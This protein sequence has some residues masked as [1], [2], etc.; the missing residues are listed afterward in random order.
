MRFVSYKASDLYSSARTYQGREQSPL[1]RKGNGRKAILRSDRAEWARK[2]L[3][4]G[5][6][7][8]LSG[9]WVSGSR[10]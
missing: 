9:L 1:A 10:R 6:E 4:S 8:G 7:V 3:E 2:R 5:S